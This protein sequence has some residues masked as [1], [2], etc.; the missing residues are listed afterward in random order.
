LLT[1]RER[2]I[3]SAFSG[4]SSVTVEPAATKA[5][6]P[7]LTGATRFTPQPINAP[8]FIIVLFLF[9]PSKLTVAHPQPIFT[10]SPM[11]LTP[12]YDRWEIFVSSPNNS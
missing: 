5:S 4:T 1:C 2:A 12:A 10:F 7:T 9:L 6:F 3:A 8:S 11:K